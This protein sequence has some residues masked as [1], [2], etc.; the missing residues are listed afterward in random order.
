MEIA[1]AHLFFENI[2]KIKRK[3]ETL[4]QVGL[5]YLKVG[6]P[7]TVLSGGEAQR[8]KL[9]KELQKVTKGVTLYI[10]D[11][12]TTGLHASDIKKLIDVL[13][14]LVDNGNSM[15]IIEHNLELIKVSDYRYWP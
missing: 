4:V 10:L 9:A 12:P 15:I 6:T 14:K 2:P 7:A 13:Q 5:G 1:E 8:I 11:E 3:F